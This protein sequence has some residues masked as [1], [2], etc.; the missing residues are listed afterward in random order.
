MQ[1]RPENVGVL[2]HCSSGSHPHNWETGEGAGRNVRRGKDI[3]RERKSNSKRYETCHSKKYETSHCVA[4]P[5]ICVQLDA[6]RHRTKA[7]TRRKTSKMPRPSHTHDNTQYSGS[8]KHAVTR[9]K[10]VEPS[11]TSTAFASETAF[12]HCIGTNSP[13]NISFTSSPKIFKR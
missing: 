10:K 12:Q 13:V 9:V 2:G 8:R 3:G 1:H 11:P 6:H 4:L 5:V 7:C